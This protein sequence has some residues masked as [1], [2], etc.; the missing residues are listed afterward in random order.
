MGTFSS[1]PGSMLSLGKIHYMGIATH[2]ALVGKPGDSAQ[3]RSLTRDS[4][5]LQ[6]QAGKAEDDFASWPALPPCGNPCYGSLPGR[7]GRRKFLSA[8]RSTMV[9]I[10]ITEPFLPPMPLLP[11]IRKRLW[12]K[13]SA[14]SWLLPHDSAPNLSQGLSV[15]RNWEERFPWIPLLYTRYSTNGGLTQFSLGLCCSLL[16]PERSRPLAS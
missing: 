6:E 3:D 10:V 15:Q 2:I 1:G 14:A 7:E 5:T 13:A 16:H 8:P 9:M 4:I 11:W 12:V